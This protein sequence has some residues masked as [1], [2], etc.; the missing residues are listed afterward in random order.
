MKFNNEN[1]NRFVFPKSKNDVSP[2][3]FC[4]YDGSV[5]GNV[6]D[7]E[8][9]IGIVAACTDTGFYVISLKEKVLSWGKFP[10]S[11]CIQSLFGKS[12]KCISKRLRKFANALKIKVPVLDYCENFVVRGASF[13]YG[14]MPTSAEWKLFAENLNAIKD[15]LDRMDAVLP[16]GIYWAMPTNFGIDKENACNLTLYPAQMLYQNPEEYLSVRPVLFIT[17]YHKL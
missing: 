3:D 7:C 6:I 10:F 15:G 17:Y 16:V 5:S 9:V 14:F 11:L 1:L 13:R 4:Y 12:G 8:D 2:G